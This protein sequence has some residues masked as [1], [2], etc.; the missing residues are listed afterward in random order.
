MYAQQILHTFELATNS[1]KDSSDFKRL[2][3]F[4]CYGHN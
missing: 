1:T 2:Q 4:V 3:P